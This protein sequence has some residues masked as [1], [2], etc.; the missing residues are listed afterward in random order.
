M[1]VFPLSWVLWLAYFSAWSQAGDFY[2][3]HHAPADDRLEYFTRSIVQNRE[4]ILFFANR[5][6]ILEFDGRTWKI[7]Q[8]SG[9]VFSLQLAGGKVFAGGIDGTGKLGAD[10]HDFPQ[11]QKFDSGPV[12]TLIANDSMLY[13]IGENS[14]AVFDVATETISAQV[15]A[16]G[17]DSW[18]GGGSVFGR[19]VAFTASALY[20][21]DQPEPN[22]IV[23]PLGRDEQISFVHDW[24]STASVV[25]TSANRLL[26][27]KQNG[28][29]E[30]LVLEDRLLL[31]RVSLVTAV[32][33]TPAL[34]A[35]GT[36]RGGVI[37]VDKS[38]GKIR[39]VIDYDSGLPDNEVYSLF[40]DHDLGVWVAH[41]YGFTRIAPDIP[42]RAFDH[43]PGLTGNLLTVFSKPG[44]LYVG[45]TVGLFRLVPGSE[46]SPGAAP[47]AMPGGRSRARGKMPVPPA[48][49][50]PLPSVE[51]FSF[52]RVAGIDGKITQLIEVNGKLLAGGSAGL[53]EVSGL[54]TVP[55]YK[56]P[57]RTMMY[58][59]S[60]DR[61][62]ASTYENEML[63][64]QPFSK[65]WY[66]EV[67]VD[68]LRDHIAH[69]FE[70]RLDN[71]W[72]CGSRNVYKL[73]TLEG[74]VSDVK[75]VPI[76]NPTLNETVG[77]AYGS[78]VYIAASGTFYRYEGQSNQLV[79]YDSLPGP[80]KYFASSGSFWFND[81][82]GW[83]T[84]D[85]RL[86]KLRLEWLSL[87]PRLRHLAPAQGEQALWVVSGDN[88]LYKFIPHENK[89]PS[90]EKHPLMLRQVRTEQ[91]ALPPAKR[92]LVTQ[93][94]GGVTFEFVQPDYVSLQAM[95]YRYQVK[96]LFNKWS[97]WSA[98]NSQVN[99]SYL[100]VGNYQLVMQAKNVLGQESM[101]ATVDFEV[102]AP[103]WKRSWFYALEFLL[104]SALVWLSIRMSSANSKYRIISRILSLLTV[105]L[106]IQFLQAVL[107]SLL[108]LKSSPVI[109]FFVQVSIALVVFPIEAVLRR[110]ILKANS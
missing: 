4:G 76:S 11:Y 72:L 9:A 40:V 107:Y 46:S 47:A 45:T 95:E 15:K 35:I 17:Q 66:R 86:Q 73:E 90:V 1:K 59:T 78:E 37:F 49:P 13:R 61:L 18:K 82:H 92:I 99:F 68:S 33:V 34:A 97:G 80:R 79:R 21:V 98:A 16:P 26:V 108:S 27:M 67:I 69:I 70:D 19:P 93:D 38:T 84:I 12:L 53:F 65:N 91:A 32:S 28:S 96:G 58:S 50:T 20:Y 23:L 51:S 14:I 8:S 94:Q 60:L 29:W 62:L 63:A 71:V 24:D 83:R 64:L 7:V 3:S 31:G 87:F 75:T 42:F 56:A 102:K 48:Q 22:A 104:F 109:E 36:L 10:R 30:E 44:V 39:E 100:P 88:R 106:L 52:K 110:V 41:Q 2:L 74:V 101:A 55:V 54:S 5:Q 105:V 6:G 85:K 43:Y 77:L 89:A 25:G 103:Y 57:I 81:G